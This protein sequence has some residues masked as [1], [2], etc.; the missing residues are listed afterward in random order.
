MKSTVHRRAL[1]R[2][3]RTACGCAFAMLIASVPAS[4][5]A[6]T[7]NEDALR[8]AMLI[9]MMRFIEWPSHK[10]DVDRGQTV[11]CILGADPI[12]P[13]VDR[14]VQSQAASGRLV[15]VRHL[16]STDSAGGCHV[17]YVSLGE[18]KHVEHSLPALVD[19]GVLTVGENSNTN[20]PAQLIGLPLVDDHIHIEVNL[21]QAQHAG[22]TISSKLLRLATVNH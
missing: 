13:S 15:Q 18:R 16:A 17:L 19:A 22:F 6:G 9:N 5:Q 7:A 2:Q 20:T 11:L 4:A 12:G 8:A 3:V 21:P 10:Q 14:I 1:I